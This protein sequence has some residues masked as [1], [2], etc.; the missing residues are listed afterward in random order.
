VMVGVLKIKFFNTLVHL[1]WCLIYILTMLG[2]LLAVLTYPL[3]VVMIEAC[4]VV[5]AVLN[6]DAYFEKTMDTAG[7]DGVARDAIFTCVR[8]DGN[9]LDQFD[10]QSQMGYFDT[11]FDNLNSISGSFDIDAT[12]PMPS[13]VIPFQYDLIDG[14][15]TGRYIDATAT[16]QDLGLLNFKVDHDSTSCTMMEDV[17]ALNSLNCTSDKGT[18]FVNADSDASNAGSPT[19]IGFDQWNLHNINNRYTVGTFGCLASDV[20]TAQTLVSRF[21]TARGQVNTIMTS[22]KSDMDNINA[23]HTAFANSF[24]S[25]LH[26]FRDLRDDLLVMQDS[27]TGPDNGI[28]ANANCKFI[29]TD[30]SLLTDSMC[31]GFISSLYQTSIVII[32]T[33]FF[34][35]FSMAAIFCLAKR[36]LAQG[37]NA[38]VAP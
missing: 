27:I 36:F 15:T 2:F 6:N 32:I 25:V 13:F 10:I 33:S 12:T 34:T 31:V 14:F 22:V 3:S 37:K 7:P 24:L 5:D 26:K 18:K 28:I 16:G 8:G 23:A 21:V 17:W 30:L 1:G 38:K 9:I 19:C 11:I 35:M 4:Q 29:G 20:S